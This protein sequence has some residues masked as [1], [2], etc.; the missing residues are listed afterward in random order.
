MDIVSASRFEGRRFESRWR[1]IIYIS[2]IVKFPKY[3]FESRW[4]QI[5]YISF[6]VKFPKYFQTFIYILVKLFYVCIFIQS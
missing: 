3:L 1:Q 5:I 6:I 2:F 4:R